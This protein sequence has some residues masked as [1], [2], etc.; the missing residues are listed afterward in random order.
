VEREYGR[1]DA[2]TLRGEG[3]NRAKKEHMFMAGSGADAEGYSR[4]GAKEG[5]RG[6][7]G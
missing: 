7:T 6:F 1:E 5:C 3:A 2:G 4:L